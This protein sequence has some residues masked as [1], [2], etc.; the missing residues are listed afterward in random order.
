MAWMVMM[1]HAFGSAEEDGD[2]D[3]GHLPTKRKCV[4]IY[5]RSVTQESWK[6]RE[7]VVPVL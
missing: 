7:G 1:V 4:F 6:R 3:D 2:E 5:P